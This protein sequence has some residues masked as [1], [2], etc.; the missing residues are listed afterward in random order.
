VR[1]ELAYV[2]VRCHAMRA[3]L[4]APEVM[5]AL[6]LTKDLGEFL[7][8]LSQT[9]YGEEVGERGR[10]VSATKLEKAFNQNFVRRLERIVRV[11]PGDLSEFLQTYYYMRLEIHNLKRILRGKFSKLPIDRIRDFLTSLGPY[12]P[13]FFEDLL[14]AE[15]L[16]DFISLL[17]RTPYA[18]LEKSLVLC[19]KYD[20]LWP[21]EA[22]LNYLYVE[23]V[24]G[25][26]SKIPRADRS[27][28]R[29]IVETE[30]DVENLLLAINQRGVE[31][32]LAPPE[33][34]FQ[35]AYGFSPEIF[36]E[37]IECR[38]LGEAI[39]GL[40][41]PY[42]GILKPILEEDAALVRA[43]LRRHIYEMAGRMRER[44]DFGFPCIFSYLSSCEAERGE[45]VAIAWGKEQGVEPKRILAYSVLPAY[46]T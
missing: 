21:V 1:P 12:Q 25:V 32:V 38:D 13:V 17:S 20:I 14:M 9:P 27:R 31:K 19:E 24:Q 35:Q 8:L 28:V 29:S 10:L 37:L 16:G 44:D 34:V 33:G 7:E 30:A 39:K 2:V 36:K 18:P 45:L 23:A 43:N 6:V 3:E 41:S 4:L 5:K 26:L 15:E 11:C 42:T 46:A 40:A 22:R